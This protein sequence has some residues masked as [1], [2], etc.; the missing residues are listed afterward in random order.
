MLKLDYR[1][2][3]C[4]Y[5]VVETRKQ[6][7]ANPGQSILVQVGE[8]AACENVSRLAVSQG[9]TVAQ[10]S[11]EDGFTLSLTP[12]T[13]ERAKMPADSATSGQTII[14]CKSDRMGEGDAELGRILLKNFFMTLTELEQLPETILFVNSGVRLVCSASDALEALNKLACRGIDIAACG[15]CLDFYHLK[16]NLQVGRV[17][18]MLEIAESQ[19]KAGR[20]ICP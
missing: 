20:I 5:P 18:N 15:L 4:P 6:I 2:F 17:T 19:L 7:L 3:Q 8:P 13:G 10:Q 14:F 12:G 16:E 11:G 1:Q 9:Y